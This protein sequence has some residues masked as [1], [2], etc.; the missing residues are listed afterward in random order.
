MSDAR[1]WPA[2]PVADW[3]ATRDSLQLWLQ[4]VG[5]IRMSNTALINHWWNVPLYV[6]AEG[7]T[8]S[9]MQHQNGE[10]F[11]IDLDLR[12]HN[13]PPLT[14]VSSGDD[15]SEG[16]EKALHV[17]RPPDGDTQVGR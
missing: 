7:F 2:L 9:M 17:V 10:N 4:I 12:E 5:K 13:L 15:R 1:S 16:G 8:T 11:Q 6:T 3:R 14:T